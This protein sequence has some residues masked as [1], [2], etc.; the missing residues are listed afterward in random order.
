[1]LS[2]LSQIFHIQAGGLFFGLGGVGFFFFWENS[3]WNIFKQPK[4]PCCGE[5]NT[6]GFYLAFFS[7]SHA[8]AKG[9]PNCF[10]TFVICA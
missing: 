6:L 10:N 1:M 5:R 9:N 2:R 7:T 3:S 4:P 8:L